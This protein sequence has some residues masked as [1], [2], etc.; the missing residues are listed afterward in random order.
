VRPVRIS[1]RVLKMS[2][3]VPGQDG[4]GELQC[5]TA[6]EEQRRR[7]SGGPDCGGGEGREKKEKQLQ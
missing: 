5:Q 2:A 4:R 6:A 7:H 3:A 1:G